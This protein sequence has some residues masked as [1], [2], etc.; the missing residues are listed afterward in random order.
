MLSDLR[1]ALRSLASRP[2]VTGIAVLSLALGIGVNAAIFSVFDRLLLRRLAVPSPHEIVLV[3]SPG[4]RPGS[5]STGDAG[6]GDAIFSYPLFRDL[7]GLRAAGLRMAGHRDFGANLAFRG[8]TSGGEGLLVSGQY[9]P[10]LGVTPALGRLLGP[11]DDRVQGGHPVVVLSH[12]YWSTRFGADP[13]VLDDTLVVNG[14]PMTIVGV[15]P[16]GFHGTT[17]LDRPQV[18]VPLAMAAHAFGGAAW[19]GYTDRANHW[20]YMFARLPSGVSREQAQRQIN[21]PFANLIRDVELPVLRDRMS[22]AARDA[23]ARREIVLQDGSRERNADR[24]EILTLLLLLFAVTGFVLAIACANVANLLLARVVERSTEISVRLSLGASAGRLLRLLL[25][26]ASLLG[27]LGGAGALAIARITVGGLL[28][29][30]PADDRVMLAFTID[31]PVLLFAFAVGCVT[32]LVFGLFPAL[33]GVRQALST[34][35]PTQSSRASGPRSANR[36]RTS[37]ATMQVSLATA[38]LAVAGLFVASLVNVTRVDLGIEREGLITFRVSPALN[39]Y[40]SDRAGRLFDA[41]EEELRGDAGVAAVTA[42][43]VPILSSS[44][45]GNSVTVEGFDPG[46]DEDV[47]ASAA[48]TGVDYFRTLGIPLLSGRD[49]TPSDTQGRPRVA[50]VNEAFARKFNLGAGAVGARMALGAEPGRP[51][52]IAIVGLVRDAKYSQVRDAAPPQFFLPYRQGNPGT[53]T[54]YVRTA[55][56]ADSLRD[57]VRSVVSRLDAN[58]PITNVRTMDEQIWE[59]TTRDRVLF[60][61]SSWFAGLAVAL[62]AVGLYAVLAYGVAQRVRE[63][64]IRIAL[65]ARNADVRRL[66]LSQVARIS[67]SGGAIGIGL[68]LGL[69]RLGQSMLFGVESASPAI[70]G[71]AVVVVL[72]AAAVAG[73]IPARRA[74]QVDPV[75]MLK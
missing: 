73:V 32:S 11:G 49:F 40:A 8:R 34:G 30:M 9:F 67:L 19:N 69:G 60:A 71:G 56:S 70:I 53:L 44:N 29:L 54:F 12:D 62:A 66:V 25:V 65:G 74:T 27:L 15:A 58:L 14:T 1:Y 23:F 46:P 37:I 59:N 10:V 38:L 2:L 63:I 45:W 22:E 17:T 16:P 64:G 41:I 4:P 50:I 35:L 36:F 6:D 52:D 5:R 42:S 61:L 75:A 26:E 57:V 21:I 48:S 39:G 47:S 33:H 31:S 13:E 20:L 24:A 43:T 51:L 7:E 68:A 72:L 3:A 18:F 55:G 28:A